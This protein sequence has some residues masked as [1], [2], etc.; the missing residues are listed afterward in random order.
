M[1]ARAGAA[2]RIRGAVGGLVGRGEEYAPAVLAVAVIAYLALSLWL[3]RGVGFTIDELSYFG[4]SRGLDPGSILAPFGGHLTATTRLFYEASLRIFGPEH[5]PFQ[6]L[7]LATAATVA[8]LL[9]LVVRRQLG[10]L[11]A[12]AAALV[13]LLLGSTPVV[14]QGNATMWAQAPLGGLIAYLALE[15]RSARADL[16]ACAALIFSVASLEVGIA[17]C[18]GIGVWLLCEGERRR[19]WIPAVPLVLYAAWWIWA[20][21][22]DQG[23]TDLSNVLLAPQ[24]AADSGAAAV[25]ALTGMGMDL[26]QGVNLSSVALGWG[27]ILAVGVV[28]LVCLGLRLRA[29]R[30]VWWGTLAFLGVLW[31]A[32]SLAYGPLR[33]PNASRYTYP[34][35]IGLVLL[36]AATFRGS[37]PSKPILRVLLALTIV[38]LA[39]NLWL[40]RERGAQLRSTSAA[41]GAS[42]AMIELERDQVPP[43][44]SDGI[45]VPVKAGDY[46]GGVD[47][48]GSIA[49]PLA[50]IPGAPSAVRRQADETLGSILAPH[51]V[52]AEPASSCGR[53]EGTATELLAP[54]GEFTFESSVTAPVMLRRFGSEPAIDVGTAQAGQPQLLRLPDDGS[55]LP[56]IASAGGAMLKPCSGG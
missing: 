20:L 3:A 26:E 32:D 1:N 42:L 31:L 13:I 30:P 7:T 41:T 27:R 38:S 47:R 16:V 25:A 51:L 53:G 28:V 12:L 17:F 45:R 52:A 50:D 43:G 40:L 54:S 34:V 36:V 56:W 5:L 18:A 4:G 29:P 44:Y 2:T 24:Y 23:F 14:L 11:A 35:A 10:G 48:F 55:D 8:V 9:F 33:V 6:L 39:S 19:L 46:L 15:R 49:T 37:R 21:K 22:F